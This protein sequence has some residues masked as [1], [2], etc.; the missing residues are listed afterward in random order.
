MEH[1]PFTWF[2]SMGLPESAVTAVFVGALLVVFALLIRGKLAATEAALAPDDGITAR[3]VGEAVVELVHGLAEGMIEHHAAR[4]VPLLCTFFVFVLTANLLGLVPGFAPPTGD[5][6]IT[7]ALGMVSFVAYMGYGFKEHGAAFLKHFTGPVIFVAP[8]MILIEIFSN[9][10]RPVSLGIRLYANMF[11]DHMVI[12]IFTDLTKVVVPVSFYL[13]GAFVCVVQA[14]VFTTLTA[15]YIAL[16]V[17][18][19]HGSAPE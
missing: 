16:A 18:H 1:H 2:G 10:F 7:F 6:N 5:F 17:A 11:A 8:L 12:E 3:N 15:I 4:Y 19:E 9:A 13:L 14:I